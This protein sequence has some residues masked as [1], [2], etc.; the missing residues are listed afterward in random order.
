MRPAA[1]VIWAA[2]INVRRPSIPPSVP[3]S[4][5]AWPAVIA[6][7]PTTVPITSPAIPSGLYRARLTAAL[8]ATLATASAVAAHG[9]R[10]AKKVRVSSRFAPLNGSA[11]ENQ[12]SASATAS[13][14]SGPNLPCW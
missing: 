12:T 1:K 6:A 9:R 7:L 13:V 3:R 14:E 2:A 10:R 4:R 5:Q 8:T 11:T